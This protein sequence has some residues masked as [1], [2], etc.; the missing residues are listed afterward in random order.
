V[1]AGAGVRARSPSGFRRR[2][3]AFACSPAPPDHRPAKR[4]PASPSSSFGVVLMPRIPRLRSPKVLACSLAGL[5]ANQGLDRR[6]LRA[7]RD[8]RIM[9]DGSVRFLAG[10]R[11]SHRGT[12]RK[13]SDGFPPR[14][15]THRLPFATYGYGVA[16]YRSSTSA[17]RHRT[18]SPVSTRHRLALHRVAPWSLS[19]SL[20]LFPLSPLFP[21][22]S[23][24]SHSS[25]FSYATSGN[26][27]NF[28][29]RL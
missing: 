26:S 20:S 6:D 19:L 22:S 24:R 14:Y 8:G 2:S 28:D 5:S 7:R 3:A 11:D 9:S 27:R 4:S 29:E 10:Q 21:K 17:P 18:L 25:L 1:R 12:R 13:Q 23:A 15:I 16:V